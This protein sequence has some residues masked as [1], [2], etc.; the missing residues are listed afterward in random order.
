MV[1]EIVIPIGIAVAGGIGSAV[2]GAYRNTK[3]KGEEFNE[4]HFVM[5]IPRSIVGAVLALAVNAGT[6]DIGTLAG[7]LGIFAVGFTAN[8]V[9]G[10]LWGASDKPED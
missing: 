10:K 5:S 4:K 6:W 1:L 8:Q 9:L 3:D 7:I 2:V